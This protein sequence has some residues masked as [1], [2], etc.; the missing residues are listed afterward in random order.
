MLRLA[1]ALGD[2]DQLAERLRIPDRQVREHLPVDVDPGHFEAVHELVVG[3]A[4]AARG[5]VYPGDPELA[6]V[7]LARPPV[8]IGVLEGVEDRLV[9][10]PEERPVCHPGTFG[11]D[12]GLL[13]AFARWN[14]ALDPRHRRPGACYWALPAAAAG[15]P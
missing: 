6:H 2:G 14:A 13:V 12:Q 8:A 11:E 1:A 15:R 9:G 3:H 10:R 4:L 5:G 7:A